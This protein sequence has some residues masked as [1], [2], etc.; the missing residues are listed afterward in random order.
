MSN[1]HGALYLCTI[2]TK[3]YFK[4]AKKAVLSRALLKFTKCRRQET[5]YEARPGPRGQGSPELLKTYLL[6]WFF[7]YLVQRWT[8]QGKTAGFP[9]VSERFSISCIKRFHRKCVNKGNISPSYLPKFKTSPLHTKLIASQ[10][11]FTVGIHQNT[12]EGNLDFLMPIKPCS[13]K[14]V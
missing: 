3:V 13:N 8:H 5:L 4:P 2:E 7:I 14:R 11:T 10:R 12:C 1:S 6:T 9:R